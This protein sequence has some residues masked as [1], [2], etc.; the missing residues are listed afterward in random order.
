M[1]ALSLQF[2]ILKS[3]GELNQLKNGLRTLGVADAMERSPVLFQS[4]FT[5]I[6]HV[7][8]TPGKLHALYIHFKD[9][10][11]SL[12]TLKF[13]QR[14]CSMHKRIKLNSIQNYCSFD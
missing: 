5:A 2:I 7:E 14:Y 10:I 11:R 13:W 9:V 12:C 6:G 3:K 8:L 4:V 1:K